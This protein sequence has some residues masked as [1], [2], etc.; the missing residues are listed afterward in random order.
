MLG[1]EAIE[2]P[3]LLSM[4]RKDVVARPVHPR[5]IKIRID[6]DAKL[7]GDGAR[8]IPRSPISSITPRSTRPPKARS[9]CVG[10]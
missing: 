2:I 8:F 7:L 9:R 1:G 5:D 3:P 4:L 10:G 6:S